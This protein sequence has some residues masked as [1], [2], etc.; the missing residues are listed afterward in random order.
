[1]RNNSN[2]L[3]NGIL[4]TGMEQDNRF[5]LARMATNAALILVTY[6]MLESNMIETTITRTKKEAMDVVLPS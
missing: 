5:T 2:S 1:L 3:R 4:L 6:L